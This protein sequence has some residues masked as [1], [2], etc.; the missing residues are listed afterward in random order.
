MQQNVGAKVGRRHRMLPATFALPVVYL[1]CSGGA[2]AQCELAELLASDAAP[3]A[4][5]GRAV[6]VSGDG[7][8][9]LIGAPRPSRG[10]YLFVS[11]GSSW[12]ELMKLVGSDEEPEDTPGISVALAADGNTALVTVS[13][14]DAGHG[15]AYVH[16]KRGATWINQQK[17]TA[18]D[19]GPGDGFGG[20]EG[21]DLSADGNT[22]VIGASLDDEAGEN[23]GAAHVVVRDPAIGKWT[24]QAKLIASDA[25]EG[26]VFGHSVAVSGDGNTIAVGSSSDD[27]VGLKSGS[28]YVF[29]R[30][31]ERWIEQAKLL[32][33]DAE[34]VA[35]FGWSVEI[36]GDGNTVVVGAFDDDEMG[37]GAGA[38]Y[39][40]VRAGER[41]IEQVKLTAADANLLDHF[42][43]SVALSADGRTA[44]VGA[45]RAGPTATGAAYL[46][47]RDGES[48][49]QQTRFAPC[50]PENSDLYGEVVDLSADGVTAVIGDRWADADFENQGA[51]Y[52]YSLDGMPCADIDGDGEVGV[53]DLAFLLV[54]WGP[55]D[56]PY[57]DPCLADLNSDCTVGVWD[58]LILL[59]NWG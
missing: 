46:F 17:L 47:V 31:G 51:A 55:C 30:Q 28:A 16:V 54:T 37:V 29:V 44:V 9:A 7:R 32:A 53:V 36:S 43:S 3:W 11:D 23:A 38:A 12:T 39:V 13:D 5:F 2:S 45:N 22:A 24:H 26:N 57:F 18:P 33:S 50:D 21:T 10:A 25:E 35:L 15:V 52:V 8:T 58:L 19:P 20:T 14:E 56:H 59:G 6:A 42:G 41:W 1:A 27:H 48:W 40:F 34:A 4:H 49:S